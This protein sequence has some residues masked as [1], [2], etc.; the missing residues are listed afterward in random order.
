M[1]AL[2]REIEHK[3]RR[4]TQM[5]NEIEKLRK[6]VMTRQLHSQNLRSKITE[7]REA[8]EKLRLEVNFISQVQF[9]SR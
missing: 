2:K 1:E 4:V 5:N 7:K 6:L 9:R 8:T 3:M